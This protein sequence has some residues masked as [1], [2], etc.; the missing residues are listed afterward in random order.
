MY[1]AKAA[2]FNKKGNEVKQLHKCS[3]CDKF[4]WEDKC[5]LYPT[6]EKKIERVKQLNICFKCFSKGHKSKECKK[7]IFCFSCKKHGHNSAFCL[8][9]S[10][11]NAYFNK[12]IESFKNK[13]FHNFQRDKR[14]CMTIENEEE[15]NN[16]LLNNL[17]ENDS[18]FQT[19]LENNNEK[20]EITSDIENDK[21]DIFINNFSKNN[22]KINTLSQTLLPISTAKVSNGN[23][24]EQAHIFLD[25]GCEISLILNS[26]AEKLELKPLMYKKFRGKGLFNKS[27]V[28]TSPVFEFE[29]YLQNEEKIKITARGTDD[30]VEKL[31]KFDNKQTQKNE[32]SFLNSKMLYDLTPHILIGIDYFGKILGL[33]EINSGFNILK[34]KIGNIVIGKGKIR[35]KTESINI[36]QVTS[37]QKIH[38]WWELEGF[39]I[40][41]NPTEKDDDFAKTHFEK[42]VSRD[43][44]GRY[45]IE[46]PTKN[47]IE[48]SD[49]LWIA[50]KRLESVWNKLNRTPELLVEYN[51]LFDEQLK[52]GIIEKC[53]EMYGRTSVHYIPHHCVINEQKKKV[54]IVFDASCRTKEGLSLNNII[55]RGPVLLP[56]ICGVLLRFRNQKIMISADVKSAFHQISLKENQRDFTRFLWLKNPNTAPIDGNLIKFRFVRMPFGVIAAPFL[57]AAVI[58]YHLE[59]Q[60]GNFGKELKKGT[61]ADNVFFGAESEKEAIDKCKNALK[62]FKEAKMDLHEFNANSGSL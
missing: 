16:V 39:G 5:I 44:N 29:V 59:R 34:T 30:L 55:L 50:K 3:L 22:D 42:T 27:I 45:A 26:F 23:K 38:N 4:H 1:Y 57:L 24:I 2:N 10:E 12:N 62:I 54:R 47:K 28:V 61:Y 49:N 8:K 35:E 9:N 14:I 37:E 21:N 40:S 31:R 13:G 53:E 7:E 25:S 46:W 52:N 32:N 43:K 56:D 51:K 11:N 20:E 17:V 36:C 33:P 18:K 41:D 48:I 58:N 6:K 19:N 60:G 15:N